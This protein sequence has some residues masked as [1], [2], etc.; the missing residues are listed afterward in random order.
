MEQTLNALSGLLLNALP[1]LILVIVLHFYLKKVFFGP[2]DRLLAE[3]YEATEGARKAAEASIAAAE[4]KAAEYDAAIRAARADIYREQERARQ[5]W[6]EQHAAAVAEA[7][8]RADS[9]VGKA[10]EQLAADLA[11]ARKTLVQD[12]EALA[13]EIVETVLRRRAA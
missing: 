6:R 7:R 13:N 4:Q 2:M 1:T 3:R 5:Q 12:S 8:Q 11:A 9:T 10:K